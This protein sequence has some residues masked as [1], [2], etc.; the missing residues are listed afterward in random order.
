MPTT[1]AHENIR[2]GQI[3]VQFCLDASQTGGAFTMFEFRVPV[4]ARVPVPHSHEFFDETVFGLEGVT[5]WMV[6]GESVTVGRGDVLFIPRGAVHGF[7]NRGTA[8][9]RGLSV[10]TPGLLG[11]SF[12]Q[13]IGAIVN[14]GGP[15]DIARIAQV[16]Q[17]HGLRPVAPA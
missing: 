12:F 9:A 11:P 3:D 17:R 4:A 10:I 14:A 16:M 2:V 5:T 6:F 13:E 8:A 15:P 1:P 7:D